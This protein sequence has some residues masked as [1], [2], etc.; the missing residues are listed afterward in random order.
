[1]TKNQIDYWNMRETG[2]HNVATE[3][4]TNRH[5][6]MTEKVDLG[7][8]GEQQR[9]NVESENIERGKLDL[10]HL[11]LGE[12]YRHNTIAEQL[13]GQK[14]TEQGRHNLAAEE[15]ENKRIVESVR[16]NQSTE[17]LT[18]YDLNLQQAKAQ[19]VQRHNLATEEVEATKA[20]AQY[21][22]NMANAD[23]INLQKEW[24]SLKQSADLELTQTQIKELDE[25]INKYSTE[26]AKL[27]SDITRNNFRNFNETLNSVTQGLSSTSK[28]VREWL[29]KIT[30]IKG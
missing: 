8:L 10:G 27:N 5:N 1:M 11:Q 2:R 16:H 21:A 22:I 4:E 13:E 7:K 25:R 14:V 19:E 9:H 29:G 18:G 3:K 23:L 6:L 30:L 20:E 12:T 24:E 26:I 15:A 28:E 17:S